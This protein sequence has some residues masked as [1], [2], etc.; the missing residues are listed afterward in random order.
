MTSL[1]KSLDPAVYKDENGK[2]YKI[3]YDFSMYIPMMERACGKVYFIGGFTYLYNGMNG[4]NDRFWNQEGQK[5]VVSKV[6]AKPKLECL[7]E[8]KDTP[9]Y[10]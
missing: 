2:F 9:L 8:Y 10:N 1:F 4:N 3:T 7:P 5:S 6:R